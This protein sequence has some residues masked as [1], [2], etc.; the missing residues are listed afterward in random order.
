MSTTSFTKSKQIRIHILGKP[1]YKKKVAIL[2]E[3]CPKRVCV[4]RVL[5]LARMTLVVCSCSNNR[6]LHFWVF[7]MVW[8]T[9]SVMTHLL[10]SKGIKVPHSARMT[11][12]GG[13]AQI[14]RK[15]LI[16]GASQSNAYFL[17]ERNIK[18]PRFFSVL[19][20]HGR[21]GSIYLRSYV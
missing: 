19:Y 17:Y 7:Q 18:A 12:G 6:F 3:F 4:G 9:H 1:L 11:K 2:F 14:D 16:Q 5:T 20:G 8:G 21:P 10:R 15:L 13:N